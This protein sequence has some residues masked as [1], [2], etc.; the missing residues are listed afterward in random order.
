MCGFFASGLIIPHFYCS[1]KLKTLVLSR[2]IP[3]DSAGLS[4]QK[5]SQT[6]EITLHTTHYEALVIRAVK[7][8]VNGASLW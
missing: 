2:T 7:R 8:V 5:V 4:G 1:V 3:S 6:G